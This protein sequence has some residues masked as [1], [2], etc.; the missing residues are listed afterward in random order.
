MVVVVMASGGGGDVAPPH[1]TYGVI[2][3]YVSLLSSSTVVPFSDSRVSAPAKSKAAAYCSSSS[4]LR[5][6]NEGYSS[7]ISLSASSLVYGVDV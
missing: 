3:P 4:G 7:W 2:G 1:F 5:K 6:E